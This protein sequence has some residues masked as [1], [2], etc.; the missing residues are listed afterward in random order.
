[1]NNRK[2]SNLFLA[3][4]PII[5]LIIMALASAVKWKSGMNIPIICSIIV[6]CFIGKYI[7]VSWDDMEKGLIKGASRAMPAVFILII[8]GT[9]IGLFIASG[10]IPTLTYYGLTMITPRLFIPSAAL[11][12]AI[13]ATATGTSFNS[14]ATI[15]L[16]LMVVGTT[17]GFPP[18]IVAG[19][20][21]SGAYFGDKV[22]PLSDTTTVAASMSG[23]NIFEHVFHMMAS[24]LIAL[25]SS[26]IIYYFIGINYISSVNTNW[27]TIHQLSNGL[28]NNFKITP[29]LIVIPLLS[30]VLAVKKMPTI[31][32]L[33][34][35]SALSGVC[36]VIFQG[37][38]IGK[39]FKIA[40]LG[41]EST[42]GIKMLDSL[43]SRGGINS[44]GGTIIL[45]IMASA[46]GG[47]LEEI[48]SLETILNSIKKVV[49]SDRGI[50]M[51]AIFSGLFIS[52]ATGAQILAIMIPARMFS[53][54][55]KE[56]NLHAKNLSRIVEA[57]G[58]VGI[59]IVP[60][61]VHAVF[62]NNI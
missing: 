50:L 20:V 14:I 51:S 55:F 37:V 6:S 46:L 22:S 12:T 18:H 9:I 19:A 38:P 26:I 53:P 23:C 24:A 49:H 17:M 10:I 16:A 34:A 54:V 42:T 27:D 44:M 43:L 7:G 57:V 15:G 3:L 5:S 33:L 4:L 32:S 48:G 13:I 25:F 62:A 36:A 8:V 56:K 47:I 59:I 58:T 41:Y 1:M 11:V 35:I 30:I 29:I 21:L 61:S 2:N 52:F 28:N 39:L 31:P 40:T 60:W 45:L